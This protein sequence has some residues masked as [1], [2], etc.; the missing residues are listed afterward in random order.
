[1]MNQLISLLKE[2]RTI[3]AL[4][5]HISVADEK[6]EALVQDALLY[7]PSAFNSQTARAVVL[8]GA[9]HKKIWE[10]VRK[11]L[12]TIVPDDQFAPTDEKISGFSAGYGTVLFFEDQAVVAAL[13]EKFTTYADKF[14]GFSTQAS[15]MVQFNVWLA[16]SLEGLGAS[17]QHYNPLIDE[18]VRAT[19]QLPSTWLLM[20][21]LVFGEKLAPA[22]ERSFVPI[23]ERLRVFK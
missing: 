23:S 19:W 8:L 16:L 6:I 1:M 2:R 3:Y 22:G 13:K 4:G 7:T 20:S 18:E 12:R 17:L 21:Q 5:S 11:T 10:I 14:D 15:G 9:Q